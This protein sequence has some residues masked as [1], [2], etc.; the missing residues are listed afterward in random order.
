MD[1]HCNLRIK[2]LERDIEHHAIAIREQGDMLKKIV[3]LIAQLRWM[4]MGALGLW[5]INNVGLMAVVR[6]I[7]GV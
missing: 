3:N 5:V 7:L 1:E 4:G 2:M 6:Q